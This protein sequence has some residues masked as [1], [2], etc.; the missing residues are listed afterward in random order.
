MIALNTLNMNKWEVWVTTKK[1]SAILETYNSSEEA[2]A[3][4][5]EE[6]TRW[7]LRVPQFSIKTPEGWWYDVS[8]P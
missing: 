6:L 4:V 1:G 2:W 7:W 5:E 3:R 8:K